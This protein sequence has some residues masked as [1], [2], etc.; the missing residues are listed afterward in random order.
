M[1]SAGL[2]VFNSFWYQVDLLSIR[3]KLV[4]AVFGYKINLLENTREDDTGPSDGRNCF[5]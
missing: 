3:D 5:P 4:V 2:N 1:T